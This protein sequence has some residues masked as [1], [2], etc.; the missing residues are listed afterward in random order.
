[1]LRPPAAEGDA[2]TQEVFMLP[3]AELEVANRTA[4]VIPAEESNSRV[5]IANLTVLSA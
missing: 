1:M 5:N 3:C 2:M 4:T